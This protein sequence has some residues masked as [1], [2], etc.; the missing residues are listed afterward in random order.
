MSTPTTWRQSKNWH[1]LCVIG[2]PSTGNR[3]QCWHM[4]RRLSLLSSQKPRLCWAAA[5]KTKRCF[6]P[7]KVCLYSINYWSNRSSRNQ[8]RLPYAWPIYAANQE[9]HE[10][11]SIRH[12]REVRPLGQSGRIPWLQV[13]CQWTPRSFFLQGRWIFHIQHPQAAQ[14]RF[15]HIFPP[16]I[17]TICFTLAHRSINDPFIKTDTPPTTTPGSTPFLQRTM[18]NHR[19]LGRKD[20]PAA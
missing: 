7:W 15:A 13:C 19:H 20:Y 4:L 12:T 6:R 8:C 1:R 16:W 11:E 3:W 9:A 5:N 2:V 10:S 17:I 18:V 14:G